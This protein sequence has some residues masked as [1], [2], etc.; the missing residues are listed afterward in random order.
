MFCCSTAIWL[1]IRSASPVSQPPSGLGTFHL[2]GLLRM[3]AFEQFC[4]GYFSC[5]F[6]SLLFIFFDFLESLFLL[7]LMFLNWFAARDRS[8][9]PDSHMR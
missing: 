5:C 9:R 6:R 2:I 4:F 7:F 8:R 3:W 1:M